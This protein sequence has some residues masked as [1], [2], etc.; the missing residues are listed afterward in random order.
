MFSDFRYQPL[1]LGD[2]IIVESSP[3]LISKL[4]Q[5][6]GFN[7]KGTDDKNPISLISDTEEIIEAVEP[8]LH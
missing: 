5:I 7:I 6:D 1:S 4:N 3:E 2:I 8:H